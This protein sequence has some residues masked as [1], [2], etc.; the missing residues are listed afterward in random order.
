MISMLRKESCSASI[1]DLVHIPTKNCLADC[2]T[3]ASAKADNLITAVKTG[4]LLDVDTHPDFRT[5]MEH[6]PTYPLGAEHLFTREKFLFLN[7]LKI[8]LAPTP[9]EG[10]FRVMFV[11]TRHIPEQREPKTCEREYQN[12]TKITSA[13]ADS[14]TQFSLPVMSMLMRVLCLCLGLMNLLF[15]FATFFQLF[16]DGSIEITACRN[17]R[18]F[19]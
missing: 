9:Q 15:N 8:P 2:L 16:A 18:F 4:R 19:S 7:T 12:A 11:G 14:G 17:G 6:R 3:K 1:H 13:R 5:L 10:S